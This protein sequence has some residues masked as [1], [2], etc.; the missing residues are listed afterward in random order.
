MPGWRRQTPYAVVVLMGWPALCCLPDLLCCCWSG[1]C[2]AAL[3]SVTATVEAAAHCPTAHHSH[4]NQPTHPNQACCLPAVCSAGRTR[5][6]SGPGTC[7]AASCCTLLVRCCASHPLTCWSRCG[8]IWRHSL[9]TQQTWMRWV[10]AVVGCWCAMQCSAPEVNR[11]MDHV[12]MYGSTQRRPPA[13]KQLR[14]EA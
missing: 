14:V 8:G 2:Q 11:L 12:D 9:K 4:H 10:R 1:G 13:Y 7:C 6:A 3:A 5:S